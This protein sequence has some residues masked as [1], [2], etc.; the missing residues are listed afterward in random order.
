MTPVIAEQIGWRWSF[1]PLGLGPAVGVVAMA[2][3]HRRLKK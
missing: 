3:L 1:L 2:L